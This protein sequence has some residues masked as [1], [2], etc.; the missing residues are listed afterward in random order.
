MTLCFEVI[1]EDLSRCQIVSLYEY[2]AKVSHN[3]PPQSV[4]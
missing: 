2:F 1:R 3:D 4:L